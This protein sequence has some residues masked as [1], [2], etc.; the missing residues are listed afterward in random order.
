[1]ISKAIVYSKGDLN[2]GQRSV[3]TLIEVE[4]ERSCQLIGFVAILGNSR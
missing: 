4:G 1:L 3:Q 2:R